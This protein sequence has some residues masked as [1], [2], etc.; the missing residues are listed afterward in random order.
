MSTSNDNNTFVM[1]AGLDLSNVKI[2]SLLAHTNNQHYS[3]AQQ[4]SEPEVVVVVEPIVAEPVFVSKCCSPTK[5][6]FS[7]M[8]VP[9]R[10]KLQHAVRSIVCV[11]LFIIVQAGA[12]SAQWDILPIMS[13]YIG[14]HCTHPERETMKCVTVPMGV[15][16][17]VISSILASINN[18]S[19]EHSLSLIHI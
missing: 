3:P 16:C 4:T 14:W 10:E 5:G 15:A 11:C 17:I 8:L 1:R 18:V 13:M 2:G 9:E 19:R 12:G 6:D 7:T